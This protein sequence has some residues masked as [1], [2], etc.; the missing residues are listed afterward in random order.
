[1]ELEGR[2]GNEL[3][4]SGEAVSLTSAQMCSPVDGRERELCCNTGTKK[5][6]E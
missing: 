2:H 3:Q 4:C 6:Y 5:E 1:M